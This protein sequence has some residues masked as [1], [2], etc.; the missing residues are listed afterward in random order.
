[1]AEK[2]EQTQEQTIKKP[3][4]YTD[5]A[6]IDKRLAELEKQMEESLDVNEWFRI[7]AEEEALRERKKVLLKQESIARAQETQRRIYEKDYFA[8]KGMGKGYAVDLDGLDEESMLDVERAMDS[9]FEKF[10][11][12][13]NK[14]S[15]IT[16]GDLDDGVLGTCE[17]LTGE[18]TL[19]RKYF[20]RHG[21]LVEQHK[22]SVELGF[23]PHQTEAYSVI[24]HEFGHATDL[25]ISRKG[26]IFDPIVLDRKVLNDLKGMILGA[27]IHKQQLKIECIHHVGHTD[28]FVIKQRKH[29][30]LVETGNDHRNLFH[31]IALHPRI[32]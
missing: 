27:V 21:Y 26:N 19:N 3:E 29:F 15:R 1:M 8:T 20:S 14:F 17:S 22:K 24:V 7:G 6:S 18:V 9:I 5:S 13:K 23:H 11:G 12:L 28:H 16:V 31:C 2:Q 4:D 25:F 10:P 32:L 30:L